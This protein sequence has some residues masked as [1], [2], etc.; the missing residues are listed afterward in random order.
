MIMLQVLDLAREN[1]ALKHEVSRLRGKLARLMGERAPGQELQA[2]ALDRTAEPGDRL[3]LIVPRSRSKDV[4]LLADRFAGVPS[5][6]VIVDRRAVERRRRE[7]TPTVERRRNERRCVPDDAVALV[8][9]GTVRG[10]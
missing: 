9:V 3:A 1:A 2:R 10:R 6:A 5:C 4:T 8:V 7:A